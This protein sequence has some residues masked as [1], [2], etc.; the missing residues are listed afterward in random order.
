M[1]S[2]VETTIP[3]HKEVMNDSAFAAGKINTSY[4]EDNK[5]IEKLLRNREQIDLNSFLIASLLLSK[6]HFGSKSEG[7]E[8]KRRPLLARG[9]FV[10][11]I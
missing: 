7:T 4:I 10:D 5:I 6:D 9:R 8:E 3:F 2:G 1:I 11:G